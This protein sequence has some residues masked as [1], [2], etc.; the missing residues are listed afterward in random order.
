M[1][2]STNIDMGSILTMGFGTI[3]WL[4]TIAIAWTKFGSRMDML[5]FRIKLLEDA[6]VAIKL[7]LEKFNSNERDVALLK[8]EVASL[9]EEQASLMK[10]VEGLR[11]GEGYIQSPRRGNIDGEYS[12]PAS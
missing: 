2:V 11:R 6:L 5:E 7:V 10:T 1:T 9:H 4:I 3:V 12:R 8:S